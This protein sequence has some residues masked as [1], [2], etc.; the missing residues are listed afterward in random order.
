MPDDC[1]TGP[2]ILT[3]IY[4]REKSMAPKPAICNVLLLESG[5]T[6][7]L[8]QSCDNPIAYN[9]KIATEYELEDQQSSALSGDAFP[10]HCRNNSPGV[11]PGRKQNSWSQHGRHFLEVAANKWLIRKGRIFF[12]LLSKDAKTLPEKSFWGLC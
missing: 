12:S 9:R 8:A 6:K 7:S 10:A 2:M 5:I 11:I 1:T 3:R 4:K